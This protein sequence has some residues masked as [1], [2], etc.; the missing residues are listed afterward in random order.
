MKPKRTD[1][2]ILGAFVAL[3]AI[4]T[5]AIFAFD[6]GSF[7]VLARLS[8]NGTGP[9]METTII[10]G[11]LMGALALALHR[12]TQIIK[13][14]DQLVIRQ[15]LEIGF[16]DQALN[17][18]AIVSITDPDARITSVNENFLQAFGF[19][20]DEV[21]GQRTSLIYSG[22][23]K[24]PVF[25]DVFHSVANGTVWSGEHKARTKSGETR[26]M[27]CT[28]VPLHDEKGNHIKN[29]SLRTD[30]TATRKAQADR[31]L[32]AML[33]NLQDE[34]YIYDVE[35][36]AMRYVNRNALKRCEWAPEDV[37]N[38]T[39]ADSGKNFSV[40]LFRQHVQPLFSGDEESVVIEVPHE[41]G[42]VEISTRLYVGDDGVPL[43]VS[44][45]RD[46]TERKRL[47]KA[48]METVSVVSHELRTP[49]TSI[50]GA[51][52]LLKSGALGP[53]SAEA[54]PVLDIADR[55]SDRLL[56]VVNDILDLE[57]MRSG[58]LEFDKAPVNLSNLLD[59]AAAMN[60]GYGDE[61]KIRFASAACE[62][63]AW[64][65]GN[66]DRLMQV[67]SNLMSNAAKF[68][69]VGGTVELGLIDNGP[70]WR[71]TVSD[72]GPGIPESV[73]Q[74]IFESFT[75]SESADGQKRIGTGLGLTIT[76]KIV[77]GHAG[78]IGYNSAVG[79][80][81]TF[82]FNLPKALPDGKRQDV[83]N[84]QIAAE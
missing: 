43:F 17:A 79:K 78:T 84:H 57:K 71:V 11:M 15:A 70:S 38:K 16:Q 36:L 55:N 9:Q 32:N 65:N 6:L 74:S 54:A 29:V 42:P 76:K 62:V 23:E 47:E 21:I 77:E 56:L 41:K 18:H 80:G 69:P 49:L 45:L 48:K 12:R 28:S 63:E 73:G 68:S 44:V 66:A 30:V 67:M 24:D 82:Y 72:S 35:T 22:L 3:L 37:S 81:T 14:Q 52:R 25:D 8:N 1:L 61:H 51:L 46:T 31:F 50:K 60:K 19:A 40:P 33:D 39:I 53:I 83:A 5:A 75:Q 58:K 7:L 20:R 27:Q 10:L 2:K 13:L 34:V 59:D 64:V 4:C 26:F